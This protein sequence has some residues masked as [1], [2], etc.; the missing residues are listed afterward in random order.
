MLL[1]EMHGERLMHHQGLKAGGKRKLTEL[2]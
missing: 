1:A 2:L